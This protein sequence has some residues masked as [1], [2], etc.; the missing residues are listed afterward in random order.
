MSDP[1]PERRIRDSGAIR[2][3]VESEPLC[4]TGC[5]EKATDGHHVLLRSQRGDD[6][7]E[8]IL[9][10]CHR[11]HR[12]YHDARIGLQLSLEEKLYVLTKL[13]QEPGMAYLERRRY[14]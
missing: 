9:P 2:S 8:N 12:D 1:K 6:L 10:L 14:S 7:P 5:G 3:K 13:G 11:C 4:R